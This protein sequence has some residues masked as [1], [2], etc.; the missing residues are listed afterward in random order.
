MGERLNPQKTAELIQSLKNL[1]CPT[2]GKGI[3]DLMTYRFENGTFEAKWTRT[4]CPDMSR[5]ATEI[6]D[7][8]FGRALGE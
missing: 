6:V 8:Q 1:R 2:H 4:C 3:R 7:S 5:R